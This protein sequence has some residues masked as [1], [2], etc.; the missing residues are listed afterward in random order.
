MLFN[1]R[2]CVYVCFLNKGHFP[3]RS[4][5]E[6]IRAYSSFLSEFPQQNISSDYFWVWLPKWITV[7]ALPAL[8]WKYVFR[9]LRS[10]NSSPCL[11]ILLAFSDIIHHFWSVSI[12]VSL[13]LFLYEHTLTRIWL[14]QQKICDLRLNVSIFPSVKGKY[15]KAQMIAVL[16]ALYEE[17]RNV[18]SCFEFSSL[19]HLN[20]AVKWE[21]T[22]EKLQ[23]AY[24]VSLNIQNPHVKR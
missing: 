19:G 5:T 2:A 20:R 9:A 14:K 21:R 23:F 10:A 12:D 15:S 16:V 17:K 11:L 24:N 6:P 13:L 8:L 3:I 4:K 7:A 22:I 1:L 18:F